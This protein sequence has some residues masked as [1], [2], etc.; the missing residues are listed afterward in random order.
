[1]LFFELNRVTDEY[2]FE[3]DNL[4]Y[5]VENDKILILCDCVIT[6]DKDVESILTNTPKEGIYDYFVSHFAGGFFVLVFDKTNKETRLY[7][8]ES[9][10]KTAYYGV[11]A[12]LFMVGTNVHE[13]YKRFNSSKGF[14]KLSIDM[15][16]NLEF[17]FDGYTIYNG[18]KELLIG[19]EL[20]V[21][22]GVENPGIN[23][24]VL[25]FANKDNNLSL[26][27]N[28]KKL[29]ELTNQTHQKLSSDENVVFLSGGL[30]SC[31][32]LAALYDTVGKDKI[33]NI[34]FKVKGT[35]HDETV[36]AKSVAN[37]LGTSIEF[38][39]VDPNDE[40][41][42]DKFE[43]IVLSM[44]N[45]YIGYWIFNFSGNPNQK[46]FA[47]Q[48][49]R[50]HTPDVNKYDSFVFSTILSGTPI[51]FGKAI[52]AL[53]KKIHSS[54]GWNKK[55][56]KALKHFHR[57]SG[58]LS[59][60]QYIE[61]YIFRLE[62]ARFSNLPND[63]YEEIKKL[64]AVDFTNVDSKRQMYNE[65]VKIKWKEQYTDDIRYIQDM[66]NLNNTYTCLP[67]YDMELSKF[68][69]SIPFKYASYFIKGTDRFSSEEV[70]VNKYVLR[71]A[72]KDVLNEEVLYRKK[73]VS[74]TNF[75]LFQ[76]GLG[77]VIKK[78]IEIDV[79][80][81]DSFTKANGLFDFVQPILEKE[82]WKLEDQTYLLTVYYIACLCVY[83][84]HVV[85][86]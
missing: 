2:H 23:K 56:N 17:L 39:E 35:K 11:N 51:P 18:I 28:V 86:S 26:E 33:R 34:S 83:N 69:S 84:K 1:M 50:L 22:K 45:P 74:M 10:L 46:F 21:T 40:I 42:V 61:N 73:A 36:Y 75:L 43:R 81:K 57:V 54:F 76:G 16:L 12:N 52:H 85:V 79:A 15:L 63:S 65:I 7:R 38:I 70:N 72:Y 44:N 82:S 19:A 13:V 49:T 80:S 78:V 67:F 27:A 53:G 31:V 30:D 55:E 62:K 20:I 8:D 29:R 68:S 25:S 66:S 47:G 3:V 48:D 71:E 77:K 14:S 9:G 32:M 64:I 4:N 24:R 41:S 5:F 37:H 59:K 6:K 58:I 60:E